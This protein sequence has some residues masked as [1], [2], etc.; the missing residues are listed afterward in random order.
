MIWVDYPSILVFWVDDPARVGDPEDIEDDFLVVG[1]SRA[2]LNPL[3]KIRPPLREV[4]VALG[5]I[6]AFL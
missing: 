6:A 4:P 5:G 2:S 3:S 1:S